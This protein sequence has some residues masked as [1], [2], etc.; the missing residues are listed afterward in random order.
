MLAWWL[1]KKLN[2]ALPCDPAVSLLGIYPKELKTNAQMNMCTYTFIAAVFT[3]AS[4]WE[5]HHW[6]DE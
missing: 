3:V 6:M 1:L 4:R 5:C 2:V